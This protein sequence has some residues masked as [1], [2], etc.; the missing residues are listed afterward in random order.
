MQRSP[1]RRE[2]NFRSLRPSHFFALPPLSARELDTLSIIPARSTPVSRIHSSPPFPSSYFIVC[3]LSS[4]TVYRCRKRNGIYLIGY[5][6]DI[7]L[8]KKTCWESY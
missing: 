7:F 4:P 2:K 5:H 6:R 3:H 8:L 1:N